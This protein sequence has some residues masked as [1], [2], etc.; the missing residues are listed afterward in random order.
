MCGE[1]VGR[2]N[3]LDITQAAVL[4]AHS[5]RVG[6]GSRTPGGK[7]VDRFGAPEPGLRIGR[8]GSRIQ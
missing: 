8:K 3:Q 1:M 6:D 7:V 5:K 4:I 2:L